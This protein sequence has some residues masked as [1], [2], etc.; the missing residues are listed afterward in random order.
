MRILDIAT[1]PF[2]LVFGAAE[3]QVEGAAPMREVEDVEKEIA[4][5]VAA[6]RRASESIESHVAVLEALAGTLPTL[7]AA[8]QTLTD[9]LGEIAAVLRPLSAAERDAEKLERE[10]EHEY[11]RLGGL[12]GRRS[13]SE[14]TA[15][16]G[17]QE[18]DKASD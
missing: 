15:A 3:Q 4:A 16:G 6:L 2:R 11:T 5:A 18:T 9:E 8:V 14:Q 7:T 17:P 10:F 1:A 12:F 13:R